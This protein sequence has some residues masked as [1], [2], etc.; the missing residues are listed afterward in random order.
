M[1][2]DMDLYKIIDAHYN[3]DDPV[4]ERADD[5]KI[6]IERFYEKCKP[7]K[8]TLTFPESYD[9]EDRCMQSFHILVPVAYWRK[10][11]QIDRWIF[12]QADLEAPWNMRYNH[13]SCNL[14]NQLII[15]GE[16]LL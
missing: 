6:T 12:K 10:A 11:Y 16:I 5:V 3:W 7:T 15:D 14:A 9:D 4:P 8:D 1:G 13:P 2:L